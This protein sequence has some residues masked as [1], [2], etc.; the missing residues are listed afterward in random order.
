D[1]VRSRR[2]R[3]HERPRLDASSASQESG[4]RRRA[5]EASVQPHL[6][7][8]LHEQLLGELR[9]ALWQLGQDEPAAVKDH[10]ADLLGPDVS[11]A[12]RRRANEIVE[13]RHGFHARKAPARDDEGQEPGPA[14]GLPLDIRFLERMNGMVPEREGIAQ[15]LEG[16]RV[17]RESR[18]AGKTRG[19][20]ER[21]DEMVAFEL[22]P[23]SAHAGGERNPPPIEVDRLDG[24]RV[25]VRA[26][27]KP[28]DG[29]DRV[30]DPDA[31]RYD[32]G[33]HG[34]EGQVV[35]PA[36]Q[37]DL[38]VAA[39]KLAL[40]KLLQRE[41]RVDAPKASTKDQD[42]C[43]IRSYGNRPSRRSA[44]ASVV[45]VTWMRARPSMMS[46][47]RLRNPL[48]TMAGSPRS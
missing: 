6:H 43:P 29:R 18:L 14:H 40:Q 8:S 26:W 46:V 12:P 23:A 5:R 30:E 10:D 11:K 22:E 41:R 27:A 48:S 21:D 19:I 2:H 25:K 33:Q 34:L 4:F 20:A 17:L 45:E 47:M 7:A 38:D 44:S 35:V 28:T 36:D 9:E 3:A 37:P 31:S 15:V 39:A 24:P 32:F 1:W 16:Q 42:A 13:L